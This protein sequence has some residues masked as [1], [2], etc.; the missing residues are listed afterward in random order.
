MLDGCWWSGGVC[1]FPAGV[2]RARSGAECVRWWGEGGGKQCKTLAKSYGTSVD[3]RKI[4]LPINLRQQ[5]R[6]QVSL[7]DLSELFLLDLPFGR[8]GLCRSFVRLTFKL[9]YYAKHKCEGKETWPCLFQRRNRLD[10]ISLFYFLFSPPVD[11]ISF[12]AQKRKK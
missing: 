10:I 11:L 6:T 3:T 8:G 2:R 7:R 1:A 4:Q 12:S 5:P 9:W